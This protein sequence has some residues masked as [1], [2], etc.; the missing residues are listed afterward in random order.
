MHHITLVDKIYVGWKISILSDQGCALRKTTENQ[1]L[2]IMKPS[3]FFL[4]PN[5]K[6]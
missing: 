2:L 4:L 6:S 5:D 1:L 3:K